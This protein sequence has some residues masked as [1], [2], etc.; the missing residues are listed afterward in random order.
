MNR[1]VNTPWDK[2]EVGMEAELRRTCR[3]DDFYVFA[4]TSGN[5]NPM[6][7]PREDGD[8]DGVPEAVAPSMWVGALISAVLGNKLP[9]PGT[10]YKSQKLEFLNRAH[11]GD[12]LVIKV[13]VTAL[14]ADRS[15]RLATRVEKL[16]GTVVVD[17][18][19][20]VYAPEKGQS[21]ELDDIPGLTVQRHVHFDALLDKAEPL[22]PIPTSVVAPE[23]ASSL[24]GAIL[25]WKHTL[26]TPILVG[27]AALIQEA[28]EEIGE[29]I[30]GLEILHE[31]DHAAAAAKSVALVHEGRAQA[32]MKGQLHT[33]VLLAQIVKR[34]GGLRT[35]RRLSHVF[36][37][38]VPG[39]KHLL[40]IS[41]AAI[42]IAPD[43]ETKVDIVQ[44]AVD[45]AHALGIEVPKVGVLSAV[46]QVN[47]K[48]PSTLDAAALA[49]MADRG[50]IRGALVDGPLA[51]DNAIDIGAAITKGIQSAV[52]GN[53][54]ILI[55][56]N[57]ESGN[58]LAK[59]LTFLAHAEAG[60]IVLG[61]KVPVILTSRADDDKARLASCA[62]AAL[63]AN[64]R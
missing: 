27:D 2:L 23:N 49:K 32:V 1:L 28:A 51:M 42:N 18:E 60:G 30:S 35:G 50:Q 53:A 59:E 29:D 54:E 62:V 41:D 37:M 9:G 38:D 11:D 34:D 64:R 61:A 46:E 7:L 26:I 48:I 44:N 47:P 31:P 19:A 45:L 6:H 14:A 24:G 12:E 57:L 3:S 21:F 33:D 39:L 55:V 16:D 20:E 25:G 17:G 4:N 13:R 22:E 40:L 15:V 8:G 63:Y 56:P 52:A 58:M 5:M 10:L 36:V 43:L